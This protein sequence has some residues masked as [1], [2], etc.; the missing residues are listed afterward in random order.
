[1]K[2]ACDCITFYIL[3]HELTGQELCGLLG[4]GGNPF[5]FFIRETVNLGENIAR[6]WIDLQSCSS[7]HILCW[8]CLLTLLPLLCTYIQ[9][10]CPDST[11]KCL[12]YR[13]SHG[14]YQLSSEAWELRCGLQATVCCPTTIPHVFDNLQFYK[15]QHKHNFKIILFL[16]LNSPRELCCL[17]H[18]INH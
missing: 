17:M 8:Y 11:C 9:H 10:V 15:S 18:L 1:M 5:L 6:V 7:I 16:G 4:G 2:E 12:P 3:H 14:N 13:L